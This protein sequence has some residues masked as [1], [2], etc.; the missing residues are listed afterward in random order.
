MMRT[1]YFKMQ[2]LAALVLSLA[3]GACQGESA[4]PDGQASV[5]VSV[6]LPGETR[7]TGVSSAGE[8]R[9]NSLQVFVF[10][11]DGRLE[12]SS[13]VL[14]GTLNLRCRHGD[15]TIWA[16]VNA[17]AQ[18]SVATL[19]DLA[20][21]VSGLADNSPSSLVMAGSIPLTVESDLS[22]S[23]P[24]SR[25]CAK[26]VVGKITK[27]FSSQALQEKR[28]TLR[29]MYL[30][31]VAGDKPFGSDGP[32]SRWYNRMGYQG[33][34]AALL[35]DTIGRELDPVLDETHVFYV[36]PNASGSVQ[37]GAPWCPRCTRL[38]LDA[39][40]DGETCYYVIDLPGLES[41]HSYVLSDLVLTRP[42]AGDEESVTAAS[43]V[44][45]SFSVRSWM[46]SSPYY[47]VL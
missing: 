38:V 23:V 45:F 20:S 15:K 41:N 42:G 13:S 1:H 8:S 31:N 44:R 46:E 19:T 29:R 32:V 47:E 9:I 27:A 34:C 24:V 2:P 12:S 30:T 22:V 7:A 4:R 37:R 17:P 33:E 18:G 40:L 43:A 3:L 14:S 21:A 16:L 6:S 36:Y 10:G 5:M 39:E 25:L 28:L 26:V 11:L 35:C